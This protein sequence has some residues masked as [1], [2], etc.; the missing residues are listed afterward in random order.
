MSSTPHNHQ[1]DPLDEGEYP[2]I[3][4]AQAE[5]AAAANADQTPEVPPRSPNRVRSEKQPDHSTDQTTHRGSDNPIGSA[6]VNITS[7]M[8][9]AS[10]T[11]C[12]MDSSSNSTDTALQVPGTDAPNSSLSGRT[13]EDDVETPIEQAPPPAYSE[14]YGQVDISQDGFDTRAR[15]ASMLNSDADRWKY[16]G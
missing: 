4:V 9:Q 1:D 3:L 10:L 6:Y 13:L 5:A 12:R 11:S 2:Q 14:T 16:E 15:V 8:C 7:Q